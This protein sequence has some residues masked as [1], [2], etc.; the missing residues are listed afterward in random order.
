VIVFMTFQFYQ[1]VRAANIYLHSHRPSTDT[2]HNTARS[3]AKAHPLMKRKRH[4]ASSSYSGQWDWNTIAEDIV[5]TICSYCDLNDILALRRVSSFFRR[6]TQ[7]D[8]MNRDSLYFSALVGNYNTESFAGRIDYDDNKRSQW[9]KKDKQEE[10]VRT[11]LEEGSQRPQGQCR[12]RHIDLCNMRNVIS[13]V[14]APQHM[15]NL[16][17]LDLSNCARLEPHFLLNIIAAVDDSPPPP[18]A[19][20]EL[21]LTG[22]RRIGG[23]A[24]SSIVQ[25]FTNLTVLHLAGCSQTIDDKCVSQICNSLPDLQSLDLMGFNRI[26]DV[27]SIEMFRRLN[28]LKYLNVD[29]CEKLKWNFLSRHCHNLERWLAASSPEDLLS[30][31]EIARAGNVSN[32]KG[33]LSMQ[34]MDVDIFCFNLEVANMSFG[35]SVR[36]G[37]PAFALSTLALAS[38]G[39]LREVNVSGSTH[40]V[41]DDVKVLLCTCSDSLKSLEIRCC[42]NLGD[43]S[44]VAISQYGKQL[45]F[46]DVSA[47]F[48][49]TDV[50]V[51]ELQWCSNLSTFKASSL[52]NLTNKS[53]SCLGRLKKM[54]LFDLHN[55]PKVTSQAIKKLLLE[56]PSLVEVDAR[57]IC[58]SKHTIPMDDKKKLTIYNGKRCNASNPF[59]LL[60]CCSVRQSS[61]RTTIQ[62]GSRP[63][64]MYH[65]GQCKLLPKFDRGMCS[66]CAATCHKGHAGVYLGSVTFFYCDCAFGFQPHHCSLMTTPT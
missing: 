33:L 16:V 64:R 26:T 11:M 23:T 3:P 6:G 46:L 41:D 17:V 61:Q 8:T 30:I 32:L 44:L 12:H 56:C 9:V 1:K 58:P 19:L 37:L 43:P 48:K 7:L 31:C 65:C 54:V 34:S 2:T 60:H 10:C 66:A 22:C 35:P 50:G 29:S 42:D 36:G 5:I 38:F 25:F 4:G 18:P 63:R 59:N 47:C 62:Q 49:M 40:V 55:C 39:R 28:Q 21:Y 51:E 52:L 27:S 20:R 57:N 13:L 45:V 14:L 15:T 24:I 53:V